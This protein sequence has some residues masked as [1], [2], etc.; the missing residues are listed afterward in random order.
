MANAGVEVDLVDI[1]L[2]DPHDLRN[3]ALVAQLVARLQS[4]YYD[5]VHCGAECTTFSRAAH[6][7]YRS[8][9]CLLGIP[10]QSP[11]RTEFTLLG[12]LLAQVTVKLLVIAVAAAAP[13]RRILT[14]LLMLPGT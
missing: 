6:P 8:N 4:G 1:N 9:E 3:T 11:E 14:V 13:A 7:A 10:N 2:S 12:N 5:I